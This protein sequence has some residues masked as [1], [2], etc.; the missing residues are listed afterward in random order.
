M[1]EKSVVSVLKDDGWFC[2]KDDVG[3]FYCVKDFSGISVRVIPCVRHFS[4]KFS[5]SLMPSLS[6]DAFSQAVRCIFGKGGSY[7]PLIVGDE[8]V[9]DLDEIL[10]SDILQLAEQAVS[11]ALAQDIEVGLA[12]YRNLPTT[13]KG[14]MPL[15]HLAALAVAG[16]V[17]RLEYYRKSFEQGDRLG[18]VPYITSEMLDRAIEVAKQHQA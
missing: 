12:A 8:G 3:D 11:W 9:V 5:I 6:V 16:D 17:A 10:A 7:T 15:R 18:F 13:A 4:G 2:K 14:A 1:N